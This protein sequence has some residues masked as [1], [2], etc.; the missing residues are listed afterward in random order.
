MSHLHF[1]ILHVRLCEGD[2]IELALTC[3]K[4]TYKELHIQTNLKAFNHRRASICRVLY[5]WYL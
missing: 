2:R 5:T 1:Y 3:V 4:S